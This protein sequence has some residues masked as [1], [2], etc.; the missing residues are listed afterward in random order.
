MASVSSTCVL[1]LLSA[2]SLIVRPTDALNG[3]TYGPADCTRTGEHNQSSACTWANGFQRVVM[4]KGTFV[5]A[6]KKIK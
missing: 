2:A 3:A 1:A 5:A 4:S 6:N